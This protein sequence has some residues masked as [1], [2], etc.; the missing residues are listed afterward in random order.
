MRR[1]TQFHLER[2]DTDRLELCDVQA[3]LDEMLT[4][5]GSLNRKLLG[6]SGPGLP[7]SFP[8]GFARES[9]NRKRRDASVAE[10]TNGGR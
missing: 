4:A 6:V 8:I 2:S 5:G 10:E 1:S 7:G 9:P 3:A